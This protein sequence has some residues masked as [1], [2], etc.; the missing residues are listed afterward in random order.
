M[1]KGKLKGHT[2][3]VYYVD[4]CSYAKNRI[5]E[6]VLFNKLMAN[7]RDMKFPIHYSYFHRKDMFRNS[8]LR[9]KNE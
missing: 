9:E 4:I 6:S 8:Q 7:S 2:F 3:P 1:I 5:F